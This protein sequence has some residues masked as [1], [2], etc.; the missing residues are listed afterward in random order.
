VSPH[1]AD[2]KLRISITVLIVLSGILV[3]VYCYYP[4]Y[5]SADSLD[6]LIQGRT[7]N[8]SD[9]HSPVMTFLLGQFDR[10]SPGPQGMLILNNVLFWSG[11]GVLVSDL[12]DH[13][14]LAW[15]I[16]LIIGFFPPVFAL[17]GTIW[18]DVAMGTSLVFTTAMC[19]RAQA[20]AR[21][22]QFKSNAYN[23]AGLFSCFYALSAR[24]NAL[25]AVLPILF[26]A[27][28]VFMEANA[29]SL[30]ARRKFIV[31]ACTGAILLLIMELGIL[32]MDAA[33][34]KNNRTHPSQIILIH[35]LVAISINTN[36]DF[37]PD[38]FTEG[39]APFTITDLERIYS[40]ISIDPLFF[41][42]SN[43]RHLRFHNNDQEFH[44]LL[45]QWLHT[46]PRHLR[47]Y[48]VHRWI[49]FEAIL[50]IGMKEVWYPFHTGIDPNPYGFKVRGGRLNR[51]AMSQ[52]DLLKNSIFFRVWFY[53]LLIPVAMVVMLLRPGAPTLLVFM[54]GLSSAFNLLHYF[55]VG[56][57]PDFRY[58]W[59][60]VCATLLMLV[61]TF[62]MWVPQESR[63]P[64]TSKGA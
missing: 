54:L 21:K 37:L 57:A 13:S 59:W 38:F 27:V 3:T 29:S 41:G 53:A 23:A 11:V 39:G 63:S 32:R 44:S 47:P 8:M 58:S 31:T 40:P 14:L 17:L 56:D 15:A 43:I 33:L 2:S 7:G 20:S 45:N 61:A 50:G 12:F 62:S 4:G 34:A 6:Q 22:N 28:W 9:W 48:I 46:V 35:D 19:F 16:I 26:L 24:H 25:P 30:P 60:S 5:M 64:V 36:H 10:I 42:D 51:W 55:L 1:K 49:M 52:L 18:K